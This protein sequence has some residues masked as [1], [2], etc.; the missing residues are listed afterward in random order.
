MKKLSLLLPLFTLAATIQ[1]HAPTPCCCDN[2]GYLSQDG[3]CYRVFAGP[4][5]YK[6]CQDGLDYAIVSAVS[7]RLDES[8]PKEPCFK[9]KTGV[10]AGIGYQLTEYDIDLLFKATHLHSCASD[11]VVSNQPNIFATWSIPGILTGEKTGSA[12]WNLHFDM[13]DG[14]VG[15]LFFPNKHVNVR[16][17]TGLKGVRIDQKYETTFSGAMSLGPVYEVEQDQVLLGNKFSGVG[18]KFGCMVLFTSCYGF[19]LYAN[20]DLS[21]LAGKFCISQV[22]NI[23]YK[24]ADVEEENLEL[25]DSYH[26]L[27]PALGLQIGVRWD[28]LF[29]DNAYHVAVML[30]WDE[31]IFWGQNQLRKVVNTD[32]WANIKSNYD[33]TFYGPKLSVIFDF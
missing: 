11:S 7:N 18:P 4:V 15:G 6:A 24:N 20:C 21:L 25:Y 10:E 27:R 1:S 2:Y 30:G 23:T 13:F 8:D 32:Y 17:Y 26:R 16:L 29:C 28:Q 19:G 33:L 5:F 31:L 22:E 9:Y 3:L 12:R 14:E